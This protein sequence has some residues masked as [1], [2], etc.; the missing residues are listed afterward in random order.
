MCYNTDMQNPEYTVYD[1][2][3][4]LQNSIFEKMFLLYGQ[5]HLTH[6]IYWFW[7][8]KNSADIPKIF[9]Q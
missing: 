4:Y 6:L 9:F 3:D 1:F 8:G 7:E 2:T 5:N